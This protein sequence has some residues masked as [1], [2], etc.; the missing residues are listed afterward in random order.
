MI[1]VVLG[2]LF[3]CASQR[4]FESIPKT[5]EEFSKPLPELKVAFSDI[6]K[7]EDTLNL[8]KMPPI[9]ELHE[10]WGPPDVIQKNTS[11]YIVGM[12]I[13]AGALIGVVALDNASSD[14]DSLAPAA[15]LFGIL[16]LAGGAP[17]PGKTHIWYKYNKVIHAK[18]IKNLWALYE[19]RMRGRWWGEYNR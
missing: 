3:G 8:R 1:I 9:S 12:G 17:M 19:A 5:E 15:Q 11:E 4:H 2:N 10:I 7:M 13:L 18:V 14:S 16:W 6:E